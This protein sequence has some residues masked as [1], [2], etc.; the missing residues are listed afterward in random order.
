MDPSSPCMQ[1][2]E[3]SMMVG[4]TQWGGRNW[5]RQLIGPYILCHREQQR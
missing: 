5:D 4:L 2:G 1:V 3:I